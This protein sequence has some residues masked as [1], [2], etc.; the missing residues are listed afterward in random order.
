MIV[1]F[2]GTRKGLTDKQR[3]TLKQY[4]IKLAPTTFHHGDCIGADDQA[5]MIADRLDPRPRI[6]SHPG[7]VPQLRAF[8]I[9]WDEVLPPSDFHERNRRIVDLSD[10]LIVCPKEFQW[11]KDGGTWSTH[12]YAAGRKGKQVTVIWPDGVLTTKVFEGYKHHQEV[13]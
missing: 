5:A 4:L 8:N 7:L 6:F 13:R 12:N 11:M 9:C 1:G 2:T 3:A 10:H